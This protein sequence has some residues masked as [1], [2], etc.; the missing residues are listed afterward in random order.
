MYRK[1]E[2]FFDQQINNI[3]YVK[4]SGYLKKVSLAA[5]ALINSLKNGKKILIAGNGGSAADAQHFAAEFVGR[6]FKERSALPAIALTTDT[7]ILTCIANDY[8]YNEIIARQIEALGK[9]GDV[10]I[11][12]STSGNSEN[13]IRAVKLARD[14]KLTTIGLLGKDGGILKDLCEYDVTVPLQ[15]T[16]RI[17]EFHTMTVHMICELAEL[18][19]FNQQDGD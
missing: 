3:K 2:F 8:G 14:M 17:Q 4:E 5:E 16:P 13:I 12:I 11:G 1:L 19:M 7:S 9:S 10:F 6:F 15:E 18:A